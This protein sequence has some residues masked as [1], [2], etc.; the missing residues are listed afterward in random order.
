MFSI[1]L[2]WVFYVTLAYGVVLLALASYV[3]MLILQERKLVDSDT[4]EQ[5]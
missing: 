3:V 4:N 5:K 2:N 1:Q